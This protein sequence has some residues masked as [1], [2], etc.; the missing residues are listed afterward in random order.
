MVRTFFLATATNFPFTLHS[1]TIKQKYT[2]SK[3][4][5]IQDIHDKECIYPTRHLKNNP[6]IDGITKTTNASREH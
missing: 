4:K 1:T 5:T 6:H 2:I 3:G